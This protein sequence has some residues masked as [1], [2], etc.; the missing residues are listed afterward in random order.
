M[1]ASGSD[2]RF[3]L[4]D[5]LQN[6]FGHIQLTATIRDCQ[7]LC[8]GLIG[9]TASHSGNWPR[10]GK[11]VGQITVDRMRDSCPSDPIT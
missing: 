9:L 5:V 11:K 8:Y 2:V 10:P 3:A 1:Q 4:G 7:S 6:A